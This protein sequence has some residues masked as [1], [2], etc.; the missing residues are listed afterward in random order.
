MK[1]FAPCTLLAV[2]LFL[3]SLSRSQGPSLLSKNVHTP[4]LP[5]TAPLGVG[6][7][8]NVSLNDSLDTSK[9]KPGDPVTGEIA[10]DV[11]YER[12]VI[13]SKGT[14]ITGHIVRANSAGHGRSGSALF[15]QFDKALLQDGEEVLLNAGIQALAVDS[16]RTSALPD[17]VAAAEKGQPAEA[18]VSDA[19]S[20]ESS[21]V[22]STIYDLSPRGLRRALPGDNT[23]Q[24]EVRKD[25]LLTPDSKGAFGR[26]ELKLYT[27]TSEGSHGTVLLSSK[28]NIHLESGTRLLLVVQPPPQPDATADSA[29]TP[30]DNNPQ[31]E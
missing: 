7:A 13:F 29:S 27:P 23:P 2:A 12:S 21:S 20:E 16:V 14:K 8:F 22:V 18:G 1:K 19:G 28:K 6:T 10:E 31:P 26:P 9:A 15:I 11:T 3:P 24:G 30:D 25:G 4:A 17:D 5:V